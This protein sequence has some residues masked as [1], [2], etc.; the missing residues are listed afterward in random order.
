MKENKMPSYAQL[1]DYY[2]RTKT[3]D[4]V[5]VEYYAISADTQLEA[6]DYLKRCLNMAEIR[7][8][9]IALAIKNFDQGCAFLLA[10]RIYDYIMEGEIPE[11]VKPE[12]NIAPSKD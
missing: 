9:S 7:K 2:K 6:I 4:A 8:F 10:K 5:L 3:D 12:K 1:L 11:N